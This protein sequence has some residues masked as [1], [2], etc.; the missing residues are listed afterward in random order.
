LAAYAP[1]YLPVAVAAGEILPAG[2]VGEFA[3]EERLAGSTTTDFGAP[4]AIA[5]ADLLSLSPEAG[6]RL[7]ALLAATWD[8]FDRV[9][10]RAP[11]E[12]RKGPRGGGRD[13]DQ[14]IDH[15]RGADFV[16]ARKLGLKFPALVADRSAVA[17]LRAAVLGTLPA[18]ASLNPGAQGWPPRY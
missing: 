9:A 11:A 14:V 4:G 2:A 7:A 1:R 3:V 5:A 8:L 12:L 13:R 16:Y 15:V 17:D 10:T 18:P 6:R